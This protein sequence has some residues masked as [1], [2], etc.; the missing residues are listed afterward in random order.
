MKDGIGHMMILK[1]FSQRA[2]EMVVDAQPVILILPAII[3]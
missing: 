1:N 3:Q 2:S